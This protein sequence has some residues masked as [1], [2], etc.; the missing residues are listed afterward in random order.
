ML[1]MWKGPLIYPWADCL[2]LKKKELH[3]NDEIILIADSKYH[4]KKS[5]KNIAEKWFSELN[6]FLENGMSAYHQFKDSHQNYGG[7]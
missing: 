2:M 1:I 4:S 3:V 6:F 7:L 5:R